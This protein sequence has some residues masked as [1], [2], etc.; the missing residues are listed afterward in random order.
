MGLLSWKEYQS[1]ERAVKKTYEELESS[2]KE[3]NL[4]KTATPLDTLNSM[5]SESLQ[6]IKGIGPKMAEKIIHNQPYADIE[7]LQETISQ[8]LFQKILEVIS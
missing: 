3:Q 7:S 1:G 8:K 2:S 6:Q 4:Q 5:T